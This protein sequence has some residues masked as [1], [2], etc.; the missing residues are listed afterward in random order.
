MRF[1]VYMAP[2]YF[3]PDFGTAYCSSQSFNFDES[4][5]SITKDGGQT[6]NQRSW[7]DT[8]WTAIDDLGFSPETASQPA[9]VISYGGPYDS[10]WRTMDITAKDPVWERVQCTQV[11]PLTW[12]YLVE[13]SQSYSTDQTIMLY[14][15]DAIG[16]TNEIWKSTDNGQIFNHWRTLPPDIG[17]MNDL[18]V[19]NSA[20][21]YA[22]CGG[23]AYGFYGTSLFGPATKELMGVWGISLA[24]Q[25]GFDPDDSNNATI[26]L[27]DDNG[28]VY[29]SADGGDNWGDAQVVGG[30]GDLVYVAFDAEYTDNG[31]IYFATSGSTVGQAEIDDDELDDIEDLEDD[32]FGG[33]AEADSGFTGIGVARDNALYAIGYAGA[34]SSVTT[35]GPPTAWGSIEMD[36]SGLAC[37]TVDWCVNLT[38][39]DSGEFQHAW[40]EDFALIVTSGGFADGEALD[41]VSTSLMAV[42]AET[43]AGTIFYDATA[44]PLDTGYINVVWNIPGAAFTP[45]EVVT[46]VECSGNLADLDN[47]TVVVPI[48]GLPIVNTTGNWEDNDDDVLSVVGTTLEAIS[49][50]FIS[51]QIALTNVAAETGALMGLTFVGNFGATTGDTIDALVGWDLVCIVDSDTTAPVTADATMFRL[52]LHEDDSVWE[53]ADITGAMGL[54]LTEGSNIVWTTA[55]AGPKSTNPSPAVWGLEDTVSGPVTGVAAS[56]ITEGE[57]TISWSAMTGADEYEYTWDGEADSTSK[58]TANVEDLDD[59]TEYDVKVRVAVGE[60]F[61]SRWSTEVSFTTVEAIAQPENQ[62]PYNGMQDAPLFPSFVWSTVSNAVSYEFE[63]STMPDFS[64]TVVE[65]VIAAPVTAYTCEVELAYDTNHYW[66]VRAVSATGTKSTWCFSNFHTMQ[67]PI[68]PLPPVT[69]PP[70]PTPIINLP[71]PTVVPPDVIVE[72]PDVTVIPP[73]VTV[74]PPDVIVDIPDI[75]LPAPTT[76]IV[77]PKIEMPEEV[78]PIYIWVIVAIGAVLTVAVII[79][80]IRTRRV[81]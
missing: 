57:A 16:G 63:L 71:Q 69:I 12:Y 56:A 7:V 31:L 80:I 81:V 29:I 2:G 36:P 42:S 33:V 22:A 61:H 50:S 48:M 25:P 59:N 40:V 21:I 38:G 8:V 26:A 13:Y 67:E 49:P 34:S 1:Y 46:A 54:W 41:I 55:P 45:G 17:G 44:D 35:Y 18:V 6:W 51:G 39:A 72:P 77:E 64:T 74:I 75:V 4:A 24:L 11:M 65:A 14:G 32:T 79:L 37:V 62:V 5:F 43:V 28:H 27:G 30:T 9:M 19:Y 73:D 70:A 3:S 66:R 23:A 60:P 68:E 10:L 76:T 53:T 15:W 20:T 47:D 52:L 58:T 78:T